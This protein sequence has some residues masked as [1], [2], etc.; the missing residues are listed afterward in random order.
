MAYIIFDTGQLFCP[1][2]RQFRTD[3]AVVFYELGLVCLVWCCQD[4]RL[5]HCCD[6]QDMGTAS[7]HLTM[8]HSRPELSSVSS[9]I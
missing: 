9:I 1:I 2:R 5:M 8:S 4:V 3:T 7:L 6:K